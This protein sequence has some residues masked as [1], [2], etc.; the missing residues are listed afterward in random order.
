MLAEGNAKNKPIVGLD[1]KGQPQILPVCRLLGARGQSTRR[2]SVQIWKVESYLV[3]KPGSGSRTRTILAPVS[4][5]DL[6]SSGQWQ[7]ARANSQTL[8]FRVRVDWLVRLTSPVCRPGPWPGLPPDSISR[9]IEAFPSP[10]ETAEVVSS[11]LIRDIIPRFGL[12]TSLQSDN[13]P[14][15]ISKVTEAF[16]SSLGI[17]W[18]LHSAYHPQSSGKVERA[19]GLIKEQLTK[20]SLE[21]R[22]SWPKLLPLSLARLRASPRGPSHLSPFELL[23]GRP[24]LLSSSPPPSTSPLA[25]YLPYLSL[26][27]DLLREHAN[28][29]LPEPTPGDQAPVSLAPGDQVL[30]KSLSPKPLTPRWEGPY[31]VILTTLSAV[32]V[33]G[34][35]SWIHSSRLKKPSSAPSP[36][37]GPPTGW[38]ATPTGPLTLRCTR[39]PALHLPE[40][41]AITPRRTSGPFRPR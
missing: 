30:I 7:L 33:L 27:R 31:T 15:F 36:Y 28:S 26:L 20:L 35:T 8:R 17:S 40:A 24:F 19:N 39:N 13:G 18:K 11:H 14:A 5:Y 41:P 10:S 21:L 32:K 22:L 3:P 2:D 1:A 9:W 38:R 34:I 4:S 25:S 12:P 37:D 6:G 23:Y 29:A 16:S